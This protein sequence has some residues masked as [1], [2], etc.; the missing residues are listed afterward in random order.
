MV[1][2]HK[3]IPTTRSRAEAVK[4]VRRDVEGGTGGL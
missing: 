3:Q 1:Q 2:L 4:A